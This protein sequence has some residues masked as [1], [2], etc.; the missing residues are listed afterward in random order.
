MEDLSFWAKILEFI[1]P[2]FSFLAKLLKWFYSRLPFEFK[3]RRSLPELGLIE[4]SWRKHVWT[5]GSRGDKKVMVLDTNWQITNTLP[6]NLTALNA[7]L[8]K[9]EYVKGTIML[10]DVNS[11]YW[12]HYPIP[13]G[14]TTEMG[15]TFA[16]DKK[17][18]KNAKT[19][20]KAELELQDPTGRKH[21]IDSV[22]IYPVELS[23]DKRAEYLK[24]EDSSKI[25]NEIERQIVAVLKN[26]VQQYKVRGRRE[27]RLGTVDW[28]QG[29]I[30]WR[31]ADSKIQFLFDK[32]SRSNVSSGYAEAVMKLYQRS[33]NEDKKII[34][35]SL[36]SRIDKKSEY[37]DVGYLII[38]CLFEL[39]HL[40]EG[41]DTA[42]LRLGGDKANGFGDVLRILDIL[43]AFRYEEFQESDLALIEKFIYSTKEHPFSIK[44]RINAIRVKRMAS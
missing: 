8:K 23:K 10:K 28:P 21:K 30:E 38:F 41:L 17:Y 43:L 6:Y 24:V 44:E 35:K 36:L 9:P 7:F 27:G 13:K 1:K 32:F 39:G 33:S 29:T 31:E 25:N 42:L 40:K 20:I 34:I 5:Y 4:S 3:W 2:F 11:Q 15:I 19:V 37:R 18:V 16:I 26:E 12:G 22:M 14:Y